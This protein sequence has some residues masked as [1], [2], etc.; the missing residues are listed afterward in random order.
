[1]RSPGTHLP[2]IIQGDTG[3]PSISC[4]N[5]VAYC[6]RHPVVGCIACG[7]IPG[8]VNVRL[9]RGEVVLDDRPKNIINFPEYPDSTFCL[10]DLIFLRGTQN[11]TLSSYRGT[12]KK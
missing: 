9:R 4:R 8:S 11:K 2:H 10:K 6:P 1:M 5:W 7:A 3:I 12:A